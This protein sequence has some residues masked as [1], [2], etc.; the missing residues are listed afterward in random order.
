MR[1]RISRAD[2]AR[3]LAERRAE[4]GDLVGAL[5]ED[6]CRLDWP[7]NLALEVVGDPSQHA[8]DVAAVLFVLLVN[9]HGAHIPG[10]RCR[11]SSLNSLSIRPKLAR[12]SAVISGPLI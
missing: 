4:S 1:P 7:T 12:P 3:G 2:L 10:C 5:R 11:A 9:V 6:A 8:D